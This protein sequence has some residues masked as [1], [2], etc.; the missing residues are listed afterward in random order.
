MTAIK[1]RILGTN[2]GQENSGAATTKIFQP[3]GEKDINSPTVGIFFED[4]IGIFPGIMVLTCSN[5]FA[6]TF[7]ILPQLCLS[8]GSLFVETVQ[9]TIFEKSSRV[10]Q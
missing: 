10:D 6:K 1:S 7:D 2:S 4:F 5:I 3:A 8:I 9:I